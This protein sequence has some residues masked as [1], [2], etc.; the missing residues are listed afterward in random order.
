MIPASARIVRVKNATAGVGIGP[1]RVTSTPREHTP[2]AIANS[3]M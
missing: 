2:D 1:N 3:I